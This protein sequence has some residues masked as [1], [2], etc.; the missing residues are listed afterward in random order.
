MLNEEL[1]INPDAPEEFF[2]KKE[3]ERFSNREAGE[4]RAAFEKALM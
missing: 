3:I 1:I 2:K 4:K